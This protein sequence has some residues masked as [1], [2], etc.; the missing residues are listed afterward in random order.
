MTFE[1]LHYFCTIVKFAS[2]SI[3]ADELNI[4]QSA[5]SKQIIKLEKELDILL[6][7]RTHRQIVLTMY[8]KEFYEDASRILR[9][10]DKMICKLNNLKK[11]N[12][13]AINIA[14]LPIS[15]SF[16]LSKI[17]N[18]LCLYSPDSKIQFNEIEEK[19]L[20]AIIEKNFYDIFIL[21]NDSNKSLKNYHKQKLFSD[22]LVALIS[23]E[24]KL[25]TSVQIP[26]SSLDS[27]EIVLPPS[28]TT[29]SQTFL[30]TCKKMHVRP[31][32][33]Q[34]SR[35]ETLINLVSNNQQYIA[36]TTEQSLRAFNLNNLKI[37]YFSEPIDCDLYI[38][39]QKNTYNF[40]TI[41]HIVDKILTL[42]NQIKTSV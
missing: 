9:E 38:F 42:Q 34:H 23:P 1:Q 40:K 11:R 20:N 2:F 33:I 13:N 29:I 27:K 18:D 39:Y 41:K 19:G 5:L 7:D 26:L 28:Y 15:S 24:N 8:G 10:Y 22:R 4:S 21:R 6:F 32:I 31:I 17:L 16:N 25:F 30:N 36:I 37:C 3:A 12:E 35:L 14:S